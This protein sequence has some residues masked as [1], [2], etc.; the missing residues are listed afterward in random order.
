MSELYD[1]DPRAEPARTGPSTRSRALIVTGIV[2]VALFFALTTFSSFYTDRLWFGDVGFSGVFS[3]MLWTRVGLFAFF[4]IAMALIVGV[5]VWLAYRHRP[6][7]QTPNQD[8]TG[9]DRYRDVV[10]P[11]RTWLLVGSALLVGLFAGTSGAGQWRTFMLWR[12][13]VPFGR[14]DEYFGKDIGFFV[15]DLPWLRYLVDFVMAAAVVSLLAAALVHYLYGGIRLQ[16]SRD[17]LSGAAQAQFSALV[18][19]FVLAKGG[20]YFLD[21]YDLVYQAG[22]LLTGIT[23]TDDRAVL[24]A[25]NILMGIAVICAILFF[26]NIW[27]RTWLLPSVGLALLAVSAVLLGLIWPGVVQQFQVRPSEPTQEAE[28]IAKNIEATRTAYNLRDVETV[29][30]SAGEQSADDG[31][32][33]LAPALSASLAKAPVI[34]PELVRDSFEQNQQA[35]AYYSVADVLDVDRYDFDGNER[36]IVLGAREL[37]QSGIAEGDQNWS[38]LYT[39]YTHGS[40]LIAAYANQVSASATGGS[41]DDGIVWAEGNEVGEDALTEATGGF[42]PRI[43]FGELSPEY[44]VVGKADGGANVELELSGNASGDDARTTYDGDSGVDVGSTFRKLI[45][46]VRFGEP[47]FLL[48]SRVNP[49]SKVLYNRTPRERV[50]KVAPWLTLDEDAYPAVVEG[51]VQWILDGYTTTD[52]YPGS[53]RES[54]DTMT[55]DSLSTDVGIRTLPTDEINYMR[56]AVKATVDAYDG[57]VRLYAWDESDPILQAWEGAFPGTVEPRS[58]I[59]DSLM[60]HLRYPEDLF[61]VQ[62]FQLAR[63]HVTDAGDW[64]QGS[65]RWDVPQDPNA[66]GSLQPP[67]RLFVDQTASSATAAAASTGTEGEGAVGSAP[68]ATAATAAPGADDDAWSLTSVFVPRSKNNLA[69]FVSVNSDATS[70][71]YGTM[72]VL[73]LADEQTQ[74]PGLVSND[75]QADNAVRESLQPFQLG[76]SEPQFGNLLTLPVEGGLIYVEPVYAL[77]TASESSYPILTY[78]LVSY[79]GQIGIGSSLATALADALGVDVGEETPPVVDEGTVT[80]PDEGEAEPSP[81]PAPSEPPTGSVEEQIRTVLTQADEAFQ[82][83]DEALAAGDLAGYQTQVDLAQGLIQ[84]AITLDNQRN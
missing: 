11:I 34:D 20:D 39:V 76:Q 52:R 62:R 38:N 14:R 1:D 46:A 51:R 43:Y 45:Y 33:G 64:Y 2:I 79:N 25:K 7:F 22:G 74:G 49:N 66:A 84:Q 81:T 61:K 6:L 28:Y 69:S 26:V 68:T 42:E 23:A 82:A 40:G 53:Q 18:G 44:S 73:E 19:I 54:F 8:Q 50:Q 75:L 83:A 78:V 37:D 77:R 27:R 60:E 67:Y 35:R 56:N 57:S 59:S 10:T 72:R 21:R 12:N 36:P 13:G 24:P 5:N 32:E 48:S 31:D 71:D 70:P 16:A 55:A 47:N 9:L 58:A 63:Y 80:P 17:R 15:F 30:Y 65:D 29:E 3:R 4:G 41:D